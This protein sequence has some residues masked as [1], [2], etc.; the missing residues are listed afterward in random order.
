MTETYEKLCTALSDAIE[1]A[2]CKGREEAKTEMIQEVIDIDKTIGEWIKHERMR[3]GM[4]QK[5]LSEASYLTPQCL[6]MIEKGRRK[7]S[8]QTLETLLNALG[9]RIAIVKK[10]RDDA[11]RTKNAR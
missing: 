5:E 3:Q 7:P 4:R 6:S 8:Q 1:E 11:E 2:R 9:Y 10:D